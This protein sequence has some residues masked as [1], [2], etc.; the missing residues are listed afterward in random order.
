MTQIIISSSD[1]NKQDI[2]NKLVSGALERERRI[3]QSAI[4]KTQ[5]NLNAFEEKYSK[6]SVQFF[7]DYKQGTAGDSDDIIDWAGEYQ[8]YLDLKNKLD[9]LEDIVV[10]HK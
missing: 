10:E 5:L 8:I 6:S 4:E 9:S 1:S 3:L 2:V 7:E